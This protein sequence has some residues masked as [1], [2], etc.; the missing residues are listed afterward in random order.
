MTPA[1]LSSLG[2][3]SL[4]YRHRPGRFRDREDPRHLG[5]DQPGPMGQRVPRL[6]IVIGGVA[7]CQSRTDTSVT[8]EIPPT[9]DGASATDTW[10]N[11]FR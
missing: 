7:R 11:A 5:T 4:R 3:A 6:P 9:T 8:I 10:R 2:Q 1:L